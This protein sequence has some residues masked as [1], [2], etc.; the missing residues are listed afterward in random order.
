[1]IKIE[2]PEGKRRIWQYWLRIRFKSKKGLG[3]LV[4]RLILDAVADEAQKALKEIE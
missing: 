2:M 3:R 1:M 4:E